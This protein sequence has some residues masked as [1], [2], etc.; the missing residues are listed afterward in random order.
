MQ[1]EAAEDVVEAMSTLS[2]GFIERLALEGFDLYLSKMS[3]ATIVNTS[4]IFCPVLALVSKNSKLCFSAK[5]RPSS[6]ETV[7]CVSGRSDIF[8]TSA[9][10]AFSS[11]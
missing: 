10:V 9:I 6:F 8:P 4:E 11:A 1:H 2:V 7:L 5:A 3:L